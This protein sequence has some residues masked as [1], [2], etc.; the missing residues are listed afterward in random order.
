MAAAQ[1]GDSR[2]LE[3]YLRERS[4]DGL[5]A[6]HLKRSLPETSGEERLRV[7][8]EL[9]RV[10]TRLLE[11]AS[12][13]AQRQRIER[14]ASALIDAVPEAETG[15]LRLT[16]AS[17][18]YTEAARLA[19]L[20]R[21]GLASA[22]QVAEAER[23]LRATIPEFRRIAMDAERR[24]AAFE[25]VEDQVFE[26]TPESEKRLAAARRN[27][28]LA[29]FNL[30]WSGYQLASVT[31]DP[32]PAAEALT[33]F[34]WLLNAPKGRPAT[35]D[36][37]N[38]DNF[39]FD[40]VAEAAIGVA[41]CESEI[42]EHLR[43][44]RWLDELDASDHI[45]D[46]IRVRLPLRRAVVYAAAERWNELRYL[47]SQWSAGEL[48]GGPPDAAA[49]RLLAVLTLRA[50]E[51]DPSDLVLGA[52]ASIAMGELVRLGQVP[53][54][55]DLL[56]RFGTA[57]LP[58]DGFVVR[59]VRALQAFDRASTAHPGPEPA[60]TDPG[61]TLYADAARA[62]RG[63]LAS[64]DT[65]EFPG[66][67]AACEAHLGLSLYLGGRFGEAADVLGG[68]PTETPDAELERGMWFAH[69]AADRGAVAAD[70]QGRSERAA[71]LR[72]LALAS[73]ARYVRSFPTSA[74]AV[75]LLIADNTHALA[76]RERAIELLLA[77]PQQE[78][79]SSPARAHAAN[80]LLSAF[81]ESPEGVRTAL[82]LR[83]ADI[84]EALAA[85]AFESGSPE[86]GVARY[87]QVIDVLLRMPIPDARRAGEVLRS[88]RANARIAALSLEQYRDEFDYR[89]LQ[90]SLALEDLG[91]A[92][93]AV[94]ALRS[95]GGP[96]AEV[97][98]RQ[99]YR[100][101]LAAFRD[102]STAQSAERLVTIGLA[103]LESLGPDHGAA[104]GI[105]EGVATAATAL[106]DLR[107]D[108]DALGT[109]VLLDTESM[110]TGTA[111]RDQLR[112]LAHAA[113]ASN[114][115]TLQE[116]AWR[117][118]LAGTPRGSDAWFE[119][120]YE[121]LVIIAA[122]DATRARAV[123]AQYVL[124]V[125]GY[126]PEPWDSRFRALERELSP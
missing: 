86:L 35:L 113:K 13:P 107:G 33:D 43:A 48:P 63:A 31:R 34:G 50:L 59:Y 68:L 75:R 89:E 111:T 121:T 21:Q 115:L 62:F 112:R 119:A 23:L 98:E 124:L 20:Q 17:T 4:L 80:L 99:V 74:N 56:E 90:I 26:L 22:E 7:A 41:L 11:S 76:S 93:R 83:F 118:M 65:D 47:A 9:G 70:A 64:Q 103:L 102:R 2:A 19:E 97:A 100:S 29:R 28:S 36:R 46:G 82:G 116:E 109:A 125:D 5:L 10:L 25:R 1:D 61:I 42:G 106:Y 71:D 15:A 38:T 57:P 6:E 44:M 126:G 69:V 95:R 104:S 51:S 91:A 123:L 92:D 67:I 49:A 45:T 96:Y 16:I 3:A 85:S 87:R 94:A 58:G 60:D 77:I 81:D 110:R 122:R 105:R 79:V 39:R 30:G 53:H 12:T 72:D 14:D 101:A 114:D 108:M 120:R 117:T 84:A 18:S 27:R 73:K 88:L 40:H 8:D 32:R 66:E 24:V 37:V 55:L 52:T 78:P 54:V